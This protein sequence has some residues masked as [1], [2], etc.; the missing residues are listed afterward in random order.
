MNP[1]YAPVEEGFRA[2]LEMLIKQRKYVGLLYLT[3]LRELLSTTAILK[4]IYPREEAQ[5]VR[6]STGEEVRLDWL[7][8]VNERQAP[9][10]DYD[11]YTCDC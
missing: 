4:E 1:P 2:E 10:Y 11:D 6:L 5:Y 9:R 3:P 7:V 8:S